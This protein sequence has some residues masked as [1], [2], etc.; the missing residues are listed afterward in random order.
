MPGQGDHDERPSPPL[1]RSSSSK[2]SNGSSQAQKPSARGASWARELKGTATSQCW[3]VA[4]QRP[5]GIIDDP[6]LW[7]EQQVLEEDRSEEPL[8]VSSRG[9][10]FLS[11]ST[12]RRPDEKTDC[13]ERGP[14]GRLEKPS[15]KGED[16]RPI[17]GAK[18]SH[19][20][21]RRQSRKSP[22]FRHSVP[23]SHPSR[24]ALPHASLGALTPQETSGTAASRR[25]RIPLTR[26]PTLFNHAAT[27]P[28]SRPPLPAAI[29]CAH[30]REVRPC[31]MPQRPVA[32]PLRHAPAGRSLPW[33]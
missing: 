21:A 23:S 20:S 30:L 12:R 4:G 1:S 7:R 2:S 22:D 6:D 26:P 24:P 3:S 11:G 8:F 19:P 33:R 32:F 17:S 31:A 14:S 16:F 10:R 25:G 29:E 5:L 27:R 15:R 28:A 9:R 18:Y 13:S